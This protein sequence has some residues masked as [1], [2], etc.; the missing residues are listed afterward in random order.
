MAVRARAKKGS[1]P[2]PRKLVAERQRPAEAAEPRP[3]EAPGPAHPHHRHHRS[4]K[5]YHKPG[6]APGTLRAPEET[7]VDRVRVTVIHYDVHGVEERVIEGPEECEPFRDRSGVT[8]I[9]I[10]GLSDVALLESLGRT[11]RLHPLTLEDVLNCGQRPK[12]E[13]YGEY[14][15][16]VMRS[17]RLE[18]GQVEGE[19]ICLFF[20]RNFVLTF[21]EVP[22]DS[23]EA[24]RARIRHGKGLIRRSGPDYLAYALIDALIDE[25][26]PVLEQF[27]ERIE[28]LEDELVEGPSP[29][30][31]RSIHAVK[32]ELL[33]LRR[34]AWPQRDLLNALLREDSELIKPETKVFLRDP[35]DHVVQAMDMIET[36]RELSSGMI[37]VY[38]SSL[39]NRMNEVMKVLTVISTIFIPLTFIAGIYGMNFD[40]SSPWNMPE[41]KW[42]FGYP[43]SLALMAAVAVGLV[44][45]FRRRGWF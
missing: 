11:F 8:W 18:R 4:F 7:R 1:P 2:E 33:G 28:A 32:R 26:F 3:D 38:L 36:F 21:Q 13:D 17:L 29:Q 42:Y 45:F 5:R 19:Q 37:D 12:V 31:L 6:T 40:T 16:V 35:Y 20:G 24:V 14:Q 30:V 10:D 27:G 44:L 34:A 22:G 15:F 25:F 43:F 41:L 39:S 9:N 23:F